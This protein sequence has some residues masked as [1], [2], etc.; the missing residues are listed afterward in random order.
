MDA[1]GRLRPCSMTISIHVAAGF[2]LSPSSPVAAAKVPLTAWATVRAPF[3]AGALW[4]A[5]SH[6]PRLLA[7][8]MRSLTRVRAGTTG[9]SADDRRRVRRLAPLQARPGVGERRGPAAQHRAARSAGLEDP[10]GGAVGH[11][12]PSVVGRRAPARRAAAGRP[13]APAAPSDGPTAHRRRRPGALRGCPRATRR[14]CSSRPRR[15][16]SCSLSA[17][18]GSGRP[19]ACC[20][21][22]SVSRVCKRPGARLWSSEGP[23]WRARELG[24]ATDVPSVSLSGT[25][26]TAIRQRV[27]GAGD[28]MVGTKCVVLPDV[29]LSG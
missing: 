17:R 24:S 11:G 15:T 22:R 1:C 25:G 6:H 20:S 19:R 10:A 16:P 4:P 18:A 28:Q 2:K 9:G 13:A 14:G 5:E 21:A 26:G 29:Q 12:R 27:L 3:A 8:G 7:V 23:P